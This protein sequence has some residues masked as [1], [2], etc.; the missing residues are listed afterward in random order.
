[1]AELHPKPQNGKTL[2]SGLVRR[3]YQSGGDDPTWICL[4]MG[5]E[6]S[7]PPR[8]PPLCCHQHDGSQARLPGCLV[9]S[10]R[11]LTAAPKPEEAMPLGHAYPDSP[12]AY[13]AH[14]QQL[15]CFKAPREQVQEAGRAASVT[16]S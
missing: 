2:E 5:P 16:G 10:Q 7:P 3:S 4:G 9:L 14:P 11:H 8:E 6:P 12:H 1:M 13:S 15:N